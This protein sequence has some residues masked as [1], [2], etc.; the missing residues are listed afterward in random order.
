MNIKVL[1]MTLVVCGLLLQNVSGQTTFTINY[2]NKKQTIHDFGASGCWNSEV[3]G[4]YWPAEK[5]DRIAELLFSSEM[6]DNKV[7][8]K[9]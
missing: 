7:T 3:I 9:E 8:R 5:K 2:H 1:N 6:D 4:K